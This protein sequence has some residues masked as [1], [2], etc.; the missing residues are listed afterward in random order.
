MSSYSIDLAKKNASE[1]RSRHGLNSDEPFAIESFLIKE[2][3]LTLFMPMSDQFSG[4]ALKYDEKKGI[5]INSN[6]SLGRQNFSIAHELYHLY[7]QETFTPKPSMAGAFNSRDADEYA[8][9]QFAVFLLMPES[10][11]LELIPNIELKNKRLGLRTIF[12]ISSYFRVSMEAALNRLEKLGYLDK[13]HR[14]QF[15]EIKKTASLQLL[16][17][18]YGGDSSLYQKG[19]EGNLIG[20]LAQMSQKLFEND[21]ISEISYLQTLTRIGLN[22]YLNE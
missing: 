5:L 14:L 12:K 18:Q 19:R 9:D 10:G 2:D 17:S 8:A 15:E 1:F 7:V 6:H 11:I 16:A 3:L 4:M 13:N 21:V 22:S 20:D